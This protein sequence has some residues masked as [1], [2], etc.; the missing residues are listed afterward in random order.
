ME[1][2]NVKFVPDTSIVVDGLITEQI[3]EENFLGAQFVI[4][5][6]TVAELEAQASKGQETGFT[7]LEELRRLQSS[8]REGLIELDFR[9]RRPNLD[10]VELAQSGEIDALIRSLAEQEEATLLTSDRIQAMVAEGKGIDVQYYRVRGEEEE[11]DLRKLSLMKYFDDQ[12]MSV[13]LR[14]NTP[15]R[16]KKGIP[17]E[18]KLLTLHEEPLSPGELE[19][20]TQEIVEVATSHEDG[21]IEM[22]SGGS[23]VVQLGDLRIA[24]AKP[25]FSDAAEITATRPVTKTVLEDYSYSNLLKERLSESHRGILVSGA[26]GMGKS[27]LVQAIA[28]FLQDSDWVVKTMEKP[29][30][31][32]VSNTISQYTALDGEMANTADI[33]LLSRPDYTVFDEMRKTKDFQVFADMRMAGIGLVG[34]V[35]A[36]KGIDALQ[37]LVGRVE[38]GMIPQIADTVVYV[39]DGDVQEVFE[40]EL[41]VKVPTGMEERD[42]SRPVIEVRRFESDRLE[43]ELYSFGEQVVVMPVTDEESKPIWKLAQRELEHELSREF[44]FNFDV[45]ILSDHKMLLAVADRNVPVV[46]GHQGN[47]IDELEDKYD[48]SIDVRPFKDLGAVSTG[49]TEVDIDDEYVNLYFDSFYSGKDVEIHVN[50]ERVFTGAVSKNGDIR[51]RRGKG[52]AEKIRKAVE[53][54]Q[55]IKTELVHY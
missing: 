13:H 32:D 47:R 6:A 2:E 5:E 22:D 11:R 1:K 25:P 7:G 9:G 37:R 52:P 34:V 24:I 55:E 48:L 36:T 14:A 42:L 29:R 54:D 21:F 43:Y 4:S 10:E 15:P 26:P 16:A 41:T 35:H 33:L 46:L 17:G 31:L 53:E 38:L 40:V 23:T 27:T 45:R 8:A 51:L 12:T 39:R 50:G 20:Y 19:S 28:E 3:K 49:N 30:D 44:D 18:M